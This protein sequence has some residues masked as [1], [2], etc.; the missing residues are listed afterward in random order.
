MF[1]DYKTNKIITKTINGSIYFSKDSHFF[2]DYKNKFEVIIPF[3]YIDCD[4]FVY[5]L[6]K[7]FNIENVKIETI[8]CFLGY[9]LAEFDDIYYAI[10]TYTEERK[11]LDKVKNAIHNSYHSINNLIQG[12]EHECISLIFI[13]EFIYSYFRHL[14]ITKQMQFGIICDY[15]KK[16]FIIK[17]LLNTNSITWEANP[18]IVEIKNETI[19]EN[20]L[21]TSIEKLNIINEFY[22]KYWKFIL[23][24]GIPAVYSGYCNII[25]VLQE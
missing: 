2:L 20:D 22:S 6:P 25:H 5:K 10:T 18:Q 12:E 23:L 13:Y 14:G 15:I 11:T 19:I 8:E 21:E 7:T 9:L 3:R 1:N 16:T 17:D 4:S 24:G